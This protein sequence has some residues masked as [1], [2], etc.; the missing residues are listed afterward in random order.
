[1]GSRLEESD[2]RRR[3]KRK[4]GA[5]VRESKVQK[6]KRVMGKR[7]TVAAFLQFARYTVAYKNF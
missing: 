7:K 5:I 1:M 6:N 2:G 4:L 3:R